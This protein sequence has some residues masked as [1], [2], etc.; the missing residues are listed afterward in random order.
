MVISQRKSPADE[1]RFYKRSHKQKLASLE[2]AKIYH[3]HI[4]V[5]LI[6]FSDRETT[7]SLTLLKEKIESGIAEQEAHIERYRAIISV[8]VSRLNNDVE[9]M[10]LEHEL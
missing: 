7:A 6:T 1:A 10:V 2:I 3:E 4:V 8:E 9:R 5:E